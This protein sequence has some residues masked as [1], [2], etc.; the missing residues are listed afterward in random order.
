MGDHVAPLRTAHSRDGKVPWSAT[1][2]IVV[3][4]SRRKRIVTAAI[5]PTCP[6]DRLSQKEPSPSI[7]EGISF[8]LCLQSTQR[9][10]GNDGIRTCLHPTTNSRC[11]V[12][13]SATAVTLAWR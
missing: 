1:S 11:R 2:P 13:L 12:T 6:V 9:V 4:F 7:R 5:S 3:R 8:F 10:V